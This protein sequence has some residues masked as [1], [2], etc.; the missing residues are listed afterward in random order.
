MKT[1]KRII[2]VLLLTI[3]IILVGYLFYTGS[4]LHDE[5]E[6]TNTEESYYAEENYKY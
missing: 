4:R 2:A 1:V 3:V 6:Q 5:T